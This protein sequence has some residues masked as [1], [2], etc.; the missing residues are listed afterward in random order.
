MGDTYKK[1]KCRS[2]V[3]VTQ[4]NFIKLVDLALYECIL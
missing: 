1:G 3:R 4:Q 2:N